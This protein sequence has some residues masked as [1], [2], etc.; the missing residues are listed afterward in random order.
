MEKTCKYCDKK[1]KTYNSKRRFCSREC[2]Y[3]WHSDPEAKLKQKIRDILNSKK[4]IR[5]WTKEE[6]EI[7]RLVCESD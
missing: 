3:K 5:F 4:E 7:L 2:F 6:A 1:F